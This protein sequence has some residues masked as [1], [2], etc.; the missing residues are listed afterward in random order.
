MAFSRQAA[1]PAHLRGR[2]G[3]E[4]VSHHATLG[5]RRTARCEPPTPFS[6]A[7][8]ALPSTAIALR[9]GLGIQCAE[10][11]WPRGLRRQ[12]TWQVEIWDAG[13]GTR[14]EH[15]FPQGSL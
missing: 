9:R 3:P 14:F 1:W 4:R 2:A 5:R 6:G 7:S 10:P 12:A 15:L 8:A 11:S 13:P